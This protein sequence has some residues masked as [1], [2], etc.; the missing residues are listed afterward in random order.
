[1]ATF[2]NQATLSFNGNITNSNIITGELQE[3]ISATKTAVMN[4]YNAGDDITYV[5]SIV[6]SGTTAYTGLTVTDNLGAYSYNTG[7]LVPLTYTAG[8]V[9]YYINGVLQTAPTVAAGP[10]LTVSGIA[11][12]AGGTAMLIYE[13][14]ANSY[15]PLAVGGTITNNAVISGAALS[16][17]VTAT[18]TVNAQNTANL[19]INK[20]L[21][22]TTV[23]E[24]GQITYTFT[25]Q[26]SGNTAVSAGSD[27]VLTDT[28][29]PVINPITVTF[30]GT[31]WAPTTNYTYNNVT[32]AFATVSGQITVPAAT[33]TQNVT[34]GVWTVNPGVSTL[35]VT[36]TV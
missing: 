7:T 17:P 13:A 15:A 23:V 21:Y 26:N 4:N 10:P 11:V 32:G 1:M 30:N 35:V 31:P 8:S 28:F 2:T 5:I 18:E 12:P 24:N 19:T 9:S 25:I 16:T 20:S 34:T 36:G 33:Y 3:V 27:I 22:P 29:D 6:N 14:T